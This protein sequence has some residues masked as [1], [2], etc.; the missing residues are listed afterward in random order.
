M[1]ALKV[2]CFLACGPA[3]VIAA[4]ELI[5]N[6]LNPFKWVIS[7][8]AF[9]FSCLG[10]ILEVG[11][12]V[13]CCRRLRLNVEFWCKILGRVWGRA[14]LYLLVACMQFSQQSILGYLACAGL[15]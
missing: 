10:L 1:G 11:P 13:C 3:A 7:L 8:Y 12:G 6:L 2:V 5:G 9:V 14:C 15:L 4:L